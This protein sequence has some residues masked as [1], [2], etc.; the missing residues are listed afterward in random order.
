MPFDRKHLTIARFN[1]DV[2]HHSAYNYLSFKGL[3]AERWGHG[4]VFGAFNESQYQM[5]LVPGPDDP[6][7]TTAFYGLKQAGFNAEPMTDPQATVRLAKEWHRDVLEVLQPKRV[8]R[9]AVQWFALYP[10]SN[11][12]LASKRLRERYYASGGASKLKPERYS[13]FHS[14]VETFIV[15]DPERWTLVMGVVGPPHDGQFFTAKDEDRDSQWW[16]GIRIQLVHDAPDGID[17]PMDVLSD[18]IA[19]THSD[20]DRVV[21]SALPTVVG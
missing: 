13:S 17:Q 5:N 19:K 4:P 20:L 1:T 15:E 2:T 10:V 8:I 14:A 11:P 9:L 12:N 6:A 21:V 7:G 16:M 18:M 3:L